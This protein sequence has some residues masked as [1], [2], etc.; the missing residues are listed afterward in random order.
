MLILCALGSTPRTG[1][2]DYLIIELT[3][4]SQKLTTKCRRN[5]KSTLWLVPTMGGLVVCHAK[6]MFVAISHNLDLYATKD[7]NQRCRSKGQNCDDPELNIIV[8]VK[9]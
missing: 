1:P 8:R 6:W 2:Y 4:P 5:K 9:E 7:A 3:C